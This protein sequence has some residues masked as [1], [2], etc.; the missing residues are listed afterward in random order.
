MGK[1]ERPPKPSRPRDSAPPEREPEEELSGVSKWKLL[2]TLLAV[3]L[4]VAVSCFLVLPSPVALVVVFV[5]FAAGLVA[6]VWRWSGSGTGPTRT[7]ERLLNPTH[8]RGDDVGR[9]RQAEHDLPWVQTLSPSLE[10]G[11][12][13]DEMSQVNAKIQNILRRL[14]RV[15]AGLKGLESELRYYSSQKETTGATGVTSRNYASAVVSS[16]KQPVP[17]DTLSSSRR[18]PTASP[19]ADLSSLTQAVC[20]F[21]AEQ[22]G[23]YEIDQLVQSVE[24]ALPGSVKIEVQHLVASRP[25]EWRL[26]ALWLRGSNEGL[27][28][29]SSGELFDA[30]IAKYFEASFGGRVTACRQPGRI[31][32]AGGE[33]TVLQKGRAECS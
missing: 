22:S 18:S 11:E 21:L 33:I 3:F 28:L 9:Y 30:D 14:E 16:P 26:V 12:G 32:R 6:V 13:S 23:G 2:S 10:A 20:A 15:E 5:V 24:R 29:V 19:P 31:S 7:G 27:V 25:G 8:D 1:Q 17:A 4:L